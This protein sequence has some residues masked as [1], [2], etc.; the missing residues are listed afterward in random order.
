MVLKNPYDEVD[1]RLKIW[2]WALIFV[3]LTLFVIFALIDLKASIDAFSRSGALVVSIVIAF[4]FFM[5]VKGFLTG[6]SGN[7][8]DNINHMH[9]RAYLAPFEAVA[10]VSGTLV[11]GFGDWLIDLVRC[12]GFSCSN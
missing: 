3:S 6:V 5:E 9:Q 4:Y 12:G 10:L 2:A 8:I 11:W 7:N 1:G